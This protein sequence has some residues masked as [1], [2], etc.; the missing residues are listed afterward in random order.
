MSNVSEFI[1]KISKIKK[2]ETVLVSLPSSKKQCK[3]APVNV[4]QQKAL[5][6]HTIEGVDGALPLIKAFNEII[7]ANSLDEEA[8]FLSVDK[9]PIL[10]Q[11]RL[12]SLGK[13]IKIDDKSYDLTELPDP[14]SL[15]LPKTTTDI[16]SNN[17]VISLE[18]PSLK[19]ENDY[20]TKGIDEIQKSKDKSVESTFTLMYIYEVIKFITKITYDESEIDFKSLNLEQKKTIIETLPISNNQKIIN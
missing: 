6:K 18:I 8:T 12:Q 2:E 15:T 4:K 3:F 10:I 11:L 14:Q 7:F 19:V 1:D 17:I 13:N 5:L 9:Y 16:K 20:L